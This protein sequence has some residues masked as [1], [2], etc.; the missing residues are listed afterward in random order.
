MSI[1]TAVATAI[2]LAL[3]TI[4]E[5]DDH[6]IIFFDSLSVLHNRKMDNPLILQ[7]LQKLHHLSCA[8]KTIHLC[9]ILS[10]IGIHGNEA[11]DMAAKESLD[12]DI[13]ASQVPYTDLKSH[14]NFFISS[15]WQ[16]RWSSCHANKLLQIKP[17]LGEW[18]P[19]CRRSRKEEVV[20]SR[21]RISH[22]YFSHSYILRR[23]DPPECTACQEIYSVR[24]VL[25]CGDPCC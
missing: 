14:I 16:E 6:F 22:T 13:T 5:S 9:W 24:H 25:W 10:H 19:G 3:D 18:P 1:F 20:V 23:E 2:D 21:L 7:L 12:Q 11:A 15:K 8:N 17:T 4:T